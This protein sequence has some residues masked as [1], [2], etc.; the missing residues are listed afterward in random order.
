M[1]K[2][3]KLARKFHGL[4]QVDVANALGVSKSAISEIEAGK[5]PV[6]LQTIQR[7]AKIFGIP[8]S[9]LLLFMEEI[10]GE[11]IPSERGKLQRNAL[12]FLDWLRERGDLPDD[13]PEEP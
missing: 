12:R 4:S 1:S 8:P 10:E 3:L 13:D 6:T 7:Y 9:S 5:R 11:Y 2:V